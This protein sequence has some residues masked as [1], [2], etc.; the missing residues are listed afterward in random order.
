M[1]S[2]QLD[3]VF[4]DLKQWLPAL[5]TRVVEKQSA[6][7]PRTP[8]GTFPPPLQK[9][10]GLQVM[11]TLG[12]DFNHGRLDI[13]AHPFCGGVPEDVRITTRYDEQH[14][15]SALMGVI[16]ETGHARYEQNLPKQWAG[17]PA[18]LARS[19]AIHESQS[20]FMEMQLGRSREFLEFIQPQV[21][22]I[23][24]SQ[25]A[26]EKDNFVALAQQV[27]PGF[28]R[29]DADEV[30]YPAHVM[31]R[32]DIEKALIE[33]EI[34]VEDIPSLWDEKMHHYLGLDTRGNY[35]EGCMQDIH[36]TDGAFG[37]FPTYTLGAMYAAQLFAAAKQQLPAISE[38]IA[39]GNLQ[40][41][42]GWLN[43]HIWQYGSLLTTD[44]LLTKA[45]GQTLNPAFFR[46]HLEQRYCS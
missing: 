16:H 22:A 28:I 18:G 1:D 9:Q 12:F 37:Y 21:E 2:Q 7:R 13:S 38:E 27:K 43:D 39:R 29:V 45:T 25:P 36:W 41:I 46:Q 30:S 26:L 3:S 31:L 8:T 4:N 19:T 17:Q 33:G 11:Q 14:M 42:S 44:E 5:L 20:L 15:L 24:G 40:N 6:T 35:R 32:Y 23:F 34:E 10:L